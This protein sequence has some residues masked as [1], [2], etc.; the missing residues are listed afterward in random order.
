MVEFDVGNVM[1]L[2]P[3]ERYIDKKSREEGKIEGKKDGKLDD[4]RNMIA[5][6]FSIDVIV[7]ITGLSEEDILNIN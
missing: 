6:G 4:A 7:R 2:N 5:E 3:V 1:I